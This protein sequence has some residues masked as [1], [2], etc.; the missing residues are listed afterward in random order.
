MKNR[1]L[2]FWIIEILI[3]L[4]PLILIWNTSEFGPGIFL[5][6]V[7]I[8]LFSLI[9]YF[10]FYSENSRIINSSV[11]ISIKTQLFISILGL[12]LVLSRFIYK[13]P[14]T[15]V[16]ITFL[17]LLGLIINL[18]ILCV[19]KNIISLITFLI[20]LGSIVLIFF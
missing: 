6:P 11:S 3:F 17:V 18:W 15:I 19:K 2:V 20:S 9:N 4:A 10:L 5:A 16:I 7:F 1:P 8:L 13:I 12:V 14:F